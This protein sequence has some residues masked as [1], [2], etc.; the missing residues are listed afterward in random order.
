MA[1]AI[2]CIYSDI[3]CKEDPMEREIQVRKRRFAAFW[4]TVLLVCGLGLPMIVHAADYTF[5][6]DHS[7]TVVQP[8]QKIAVTGGDSYTVTYQILEETFATETVAA[9]AEHQVLDISEDQ[10]P[11][12]KEF[13]GWTVSY[14]YLSGGMTGS[15]TLTANLT[16]RV[17]TITLKDGDA[18][19]GTIRGTAGTVLTEPSVPTKEGYTFAGWNPALP[20]TMPAEDLTVKAVWDPN[21]YNITY[22]LDG[23]TNGANNPGSYVYGTGVVS[24][25]DASKDG[26]TF[27]GWFSDGGFATQVTTIAPTHTGDITL[28]AKF[29]EQSRVI[30]AGTHTLTAGVP[31]QLGSSVTRVSGDSSTYVGGSTFYV[32]ADGT[33]TFS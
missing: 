19:L 5:E 11:A 28:Y 31:Y 4:M 15:V 30:E 8:G 20:E 14:V 10:I 29:E 2:L 24:F 3:P 9:G 16:D 17:Y 12:G 7:G 27:A 6:S 22:V 1:C 33:Y 23:G 26:Y 13:S 32:P 21:S 18:T 25:A